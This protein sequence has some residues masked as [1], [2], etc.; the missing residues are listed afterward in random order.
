MK[1]QELFDKLFLK[2]DK[3]ELGLLQDLEKM[4]DSVFSQAG[5]LESVFQKIE[6]IQ[7]ELKSEFIAL[8]KEL[9][10]YDS[11]YGSFLRSSKELGV[12]VPKTAENSYK[13]TIAM[14]KNAMATYKKYKID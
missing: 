14:I 9:S 3:V 5:K 11:A 10:K 6:K 12:E 2:S 13:S 4:S 8:E 1:G 7:D